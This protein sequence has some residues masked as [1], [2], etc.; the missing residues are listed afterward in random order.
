MLAAWLL[1]A[2]VHRMSAREAAT[3]FAVVAAVHVPI[4]LVGYRVGAR[5]TPI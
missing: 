2:P 1:L 5:D 4:N 3:G